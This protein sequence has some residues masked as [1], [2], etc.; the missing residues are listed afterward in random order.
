MKAAALQVLVV[1]AVLGLPLGIAVGAAFLLS[2]GHADAQ[3]R[4][5]LLI[6]GEFERAFDGRLKQVGVTPMAATTVETNIRDVFAAGTPSMDAP[7]LTHAWMVMKRERYGFGY[8]R[9][10]I[11]KVMGT[12]DLQ[13]EAIAAGLVRVEGRGA[14]APLR[15]HP[16]RA[17]LR[18]GRRRGALHPAA[19]AAQHPAR[20]AHGLR[21][22][23]PRR[24]PDA[25]RAPS[26]VTLSDGA[27]RLG[28]DELGPPRRPAGRPP[29]LISK[30]ESPSWTEALQTRW[31]AVV[32]NHL[33]RLD[34]SLP[35]TAIPEGDVEALGELV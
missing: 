29:S 13:S 15:A 20:A 1:W 19:G 33:W 6:P 9:L 3:H 11:G 5:A 35:E 28:L 31:L 27:R 16:G 4:T 32:T 30:H 25:R 2:A 14:A 12:V 34:Y 24:A 22:P 21:R 17:R 23:A 18:E 26:R 10:D 8:I 7:E